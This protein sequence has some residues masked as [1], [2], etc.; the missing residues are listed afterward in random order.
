M[1]TDMRLRTPLTVRAAYVDYV[2]DDGRL[3][4]QRDSHWT[5]TRT[6]SGFSVPKN[7]V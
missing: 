2:I 1:N 5:A 4:A 7:S 3:R 6:T